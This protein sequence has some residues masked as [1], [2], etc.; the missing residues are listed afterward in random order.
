MNT[1]LFVLDHHQC[2]PPSSY[3]MSPE[4]HPSFSSQKLPMLYFLGRSERLLTLFCLL[5]YPGWK[6]ILTFTQDFISVWAVLN[7]FCFPSIFRISTSLLQSSDWISDLPQEGSLHF[8]RIQHKKR[9]NR[10]SLNCFRTRWLWAW[11]S[12]PD[13][14][15]EIHTHTVVWRRVPWPTVLQHVYIC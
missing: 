12:S 1:I 4:I 7:L 10:L 13:V 3:F 6:R 2:I 5:F 15:E 8:G 14:T 9:Y 11:F